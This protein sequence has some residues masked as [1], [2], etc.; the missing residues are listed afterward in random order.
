MLLL[1]TRRSGP[2]PQAPEELSL[3]AEAVLDV[4]DQVP[5]G[6]VTTYGR[7]AAVLAEAGL[8]GGPR[9]VGAVMS[10]HGGAVAWWRVL[11]ADGSAPVCDPDGALARWREEGTPLR[12]GGRA[13][14]DLAR[15]L[16]DLAAPDWLAG[17]SP[18]DGSSADG[19]GRVGQP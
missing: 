16:A 9:S 8:G 12:P 7:V 13:R 5:P 10:A 4:V 19:E 18:V 6:S 15:A 14:V 3:Y 2:G 1:V 17:A 11:P